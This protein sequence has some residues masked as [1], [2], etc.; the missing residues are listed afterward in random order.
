[1]D[2]ST[3]EVGLHSYPTGA[4]NLLSVLNSCY[5]ILHKIPFSI[6]LIHPAHLQEGRSPLNRRLVPEETCNLYRL[7]LSN[8]WRN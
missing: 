5:G 1:M 8:G 4:K 2:R 7:Q 3:P 6:P